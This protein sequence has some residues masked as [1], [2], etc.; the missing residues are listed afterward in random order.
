MRD[1]KR[2]FKLMKYTYHY[3]SKDEKFMPL[4][5][6]VVGI[7]ALL[8]CIKDAFYIVVASPMLVLSIAYV[9]SYYYSLTCAHMAGASGLRKNLSLIIPNVLMVAGVF[10]A[11]L[12]ITVVLTILVHFYPQMASEYAKGLL[13]STVMTAVLIIFN[14][15][16][17]KH[18]WTGVILVAIVLIP[19]AAI[20]PMLLRDMDTFLGRPLN[21]QWGLVV[22]GLALL[23]ST[24]ISCVLRVVLYKVPAMRGKLGKQMLHA[25]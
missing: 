10:W 21:L 4:I 18:Y 19:S 9:G 5:L 25:M 13:D 3:Q 6:F 17:D 12:L 23:I 8:G 1:L 14:G 11:Y 15:I 20:L 24:I 7:A 16:C 22:Y 2:A